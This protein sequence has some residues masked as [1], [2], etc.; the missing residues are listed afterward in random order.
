MVLTSG[1]ACTESAAAYPAACR[2]TCATLLNQGDSKRG[3][4]TFNGR[5]MRDMPCYH[6][7]ACRPLQA[8]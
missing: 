7:A 4:H 8:W 2:A 5:Q 3:M 1:R 6:H